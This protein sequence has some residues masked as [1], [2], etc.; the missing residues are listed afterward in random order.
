M[1][2]YVLVVS[3]GGLLDGVLDGQAQVQRALVQEFTKTVL[4]DISDEVIEAVVALDHG[5]KAVADV[6][7]SSSRDSVK[8]GLDD[9]DNEVVVLAPGSNA[10]ELVED[11]LTELSLEDQS[12]VLHILGEELLDISTEAIGLHKLCI[13][14]A[15]LSCAH[16]ANA[17]G[18]RNV[19]WRD[20]GIDIL[21]HLLQCGF[22]VAAENFHA[23]VALDLDVEL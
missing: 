12:K 9:L 18:V 22:G 16:G 3:L 13:V 4:P 15:A 7:D 1:L 10:L 6:G 5:V 14:L 23:R 11:A 2:F 20:L 17:V 19:G 21:E 8:T